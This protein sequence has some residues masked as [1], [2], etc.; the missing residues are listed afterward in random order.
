M[1]REIAT[2]QTTS[3]MAGNLLPRFQMIRRS[4][5]RFR[6]CIELDSNINKEAKFARYPW[7]ISL[8]LGSTNKLRSP[9]LI[10]TLAYL[11]PQ[12]SDTPLRSITFK[13]L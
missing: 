12:G 8:F 10:L 4:R 7:Y 13:A 1:Q 5:G 11:I 6:Q 2:V 3:F 9:L